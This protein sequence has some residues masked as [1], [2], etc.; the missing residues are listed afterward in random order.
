MPEPLKNLYSEQLLEAL[1]IEIQRSYRAFEPGHFVSLVLD[2]LWVERELKQRM[3]HLSRSLHECLPAN[4]PEAINILKRVAPKFTGFEYMFFPGFVALYGMDDYDVSIDA[5]EHFTE[6]ASSEFAVRPFIQ[7]YSSRMMA[8]MN[9]WAKSDNFHVRRLASEGCRP[10]LPWAMALPEFKNDPRPVLPILEKLKDDESEYVRRSV[11][12]NLND[13]AKDNP[14]IVVDVAARWL[15]DNPHTDR[16]VKHACRTLLKQG[17]PD[18]MKL[19][20]FA[21]PRHISVNDLFIQEA[22]DMGG[23]LSFAFTLKSA[24]QSLGKLRVEYAMDFMKKN[25]KPSRKLFKLSELQSSKRAKS[26]RKAYSFRKISTRKYYAGRHGV[27]IIVN[28]YELASGSFKLHEPFS[29]TP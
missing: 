12:N 22:V 9:D 17:Q 19:F 7:R 3:D 29:T 15:G 2:D 8:Q 13:I 20:G 18:I 24:N 11:S 28:G 1:C 25:G 26:Y 21:R 10:R 23:V 5:L 6:Y 4:Y 16:L 14:S 27:A